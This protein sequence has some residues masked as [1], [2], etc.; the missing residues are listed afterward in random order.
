MRVRLESA[1]PGLKKAWNRPAQ[2]PA[3]S[4]DSERPFLLEVSKSAKVSGLFLMDNS[5]KI[6]WPI[7]KFLGLPGAILRQ[8]MRAWDAR[9]GQTC[10]TVLCPH[11]SA[12][13]RCVEAPVQHYLFSLSCPC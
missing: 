6:S 13:S 9:G 12:L 5:I 4:R 11:L 1:Y 2:P 10:L 8:K 7:K 3:T